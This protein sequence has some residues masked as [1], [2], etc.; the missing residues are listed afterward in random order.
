MV[1]RAIFSVRGTPPSSLRPVLTSVL[2]SVLGSAA[3]A[4][5]TRRTSGRLRSQPPAPTPTFVPL[6]TT[7]AEHAIS[8]TATTTAL[9]PSLPGSISISSLSGHVTLGLFG[10]EPAKYVGGTMSQLLAGLSQV[11]GELKR[12]WKER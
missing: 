6:S 1:W 2:H 8:D 7:L 10:Q 9:V 3:P 11:G 12:M 4:T 5:S